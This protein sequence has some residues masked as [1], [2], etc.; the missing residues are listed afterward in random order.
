MDPA[1]LLSIMARA[2]CLR[3]K[4]VPLTFVASTRSQSAQLTALNGQCRAC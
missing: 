1:V 2:A 4:A 3:V